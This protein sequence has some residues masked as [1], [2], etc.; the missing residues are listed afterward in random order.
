MALLSGIDDPVLLIIL[1]AAA[2]LALVLWLVRVMFNDRTETIATQREDLRAERATVA[3]LRMAAELERDALSE[4]LR[5]LESQATARHAEMR[6]WRVANGV[7]LV[8]DSAEAREA[9]HLVALVHE[10]VVVD[11]SNGG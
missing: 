3:A 1:V 2:P 4:R 8:G 6:K 5:D 9:S 10:R 7:P 11:D